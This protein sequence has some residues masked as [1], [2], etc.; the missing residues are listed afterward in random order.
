MC[1]TIYI[2]IYSIHETRFWKKSKFKQ[3][4][5]IVF[6]TH[7]RNNLFE[8]SSSIIYVRVN[9]RF[10]LRVGR[11][12][13][14]QR[15]R[16]GKGEQIA[17]GEVGWG[18]GAED[19]SIRL[20]WPIRRSKTIATRLSACLVRESFQRC[21]RFHGS[22]GPR[23]REE[24]SNRKPKRARFSPLRSIVYRWGSRNS[25]SERVVFPFLF[26]FVY[27]SRRSAFPIII[28]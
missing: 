16:S 22:G 8:D 18:R 28:T 24:R 19:R 15:E 23:S 25:T 27:L 5:S 1:K 2:Y 20:G 10:V 26:C 14:A 13:R 11:K 9:C 12:V 3:N 21:P 6:L 17:I 7:L 4:V